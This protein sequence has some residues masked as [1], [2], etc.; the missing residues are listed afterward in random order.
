[1]T[2][3]EFTSAL[4]TIGIPIS[5][6]HAPNGTK[7]PFINYTWVTDSALN[8][9]NKVY[10]KKAVVTVDL[11]ADKKG[12]LNQYSE[13]LENL[14]EQLELPWGVNEGWSDSEGIYLRTYDMEV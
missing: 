8:A 3:S 9:D 13:L 12:M 14:F 6:E 1:M 5:Y 11:V 2:Q 7:V 10:S 4:E